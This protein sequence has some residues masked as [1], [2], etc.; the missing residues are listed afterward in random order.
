[1][2]VVY[3]VTYETDGPWVLHYGGYQKTKEQRTFYTGSEECLEGFPFK[4]ISIEK[5]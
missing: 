3:K 5:K 1:M 4:I 2:F